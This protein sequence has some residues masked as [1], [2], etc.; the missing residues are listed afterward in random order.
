M[1]GTSSLYVARLLSRLA[2]EILFFGTAIFHTSSFRNPNYVFSS[3]TRYYTAFYLFCRDVFA[4]ILY[5]RKFSSLHKTYAFAAAFYGTDFVNRFA[6]GFQNRF[7][8][9]RM[10]GIHRHNHADT[11][12]KGI[13]HFGSGDIACLLH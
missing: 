1:P 11:H 5:F 2:L 6:C 7:G 9:V 3:N 13:V 12:V 8:F 10:C 4:K